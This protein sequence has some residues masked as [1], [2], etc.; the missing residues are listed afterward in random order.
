MPQFHYELLVILGLLA[1]A[2]FLFAEHRSSVRHAFYRIVTDLQGGVGGGPV[3]NGSTER[4]TGWQ[5]LV[6]TAPR[7]PDDA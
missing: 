4:D 7:L 2:I 3:Q 1:A 6:Q 5:A